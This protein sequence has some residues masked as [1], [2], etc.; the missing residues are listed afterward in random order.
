MNKQAFNRVADELGVSAD[1][2]RGDISSATKAIA[3]ELLIED[4]ARHPAFA[5]V[6][7]GVEDSFEG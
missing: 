3:L 5:T 7:R 4:L 6:R 2:L 1:E